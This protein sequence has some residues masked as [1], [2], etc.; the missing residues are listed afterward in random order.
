LLAF[1]LGREA[2]VRWIRGLDRILPGRRIIET[3][4]VFDTFPPT[5]T[6]FIH[7]S[8]G[9][10][11]EIFGASTTNTIVLFVGIYD[12]CRSW[13]SMSCRSGSRHRLV[14]GMSTWSYL[15]PIGRFNRASENV[16]VEWIVVDGG[17]G[18]R[19]SLASTI[20]GYI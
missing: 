14:D 1:I 11:V 19:E 20:I 5:M 2:L 13:S 6:H 18:T 3:S 16:L 8:P 15:V 7:G 9:S 17:R 4:E 12:S 10:L